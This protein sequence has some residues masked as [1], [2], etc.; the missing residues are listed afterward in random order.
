[1]QP[2]TAL[3]PVHHRRTLRAD[4]TIVEVLTVFCAVKGR[5]IR[6][7]LCNDCHRCH[8]VVLG[9]NDSPR[10]IMCDSVP[11]NAEADPGVAPSPH[12]TPVWGAMSSA[13]LCVESD[14]AAEDLAK[15]LVDASIDCAPVTDPDGVLLGVVSRLDL[16]RWQWRDGAPAVS[17]QSLMHPGRRIV[18]VMP[19]ATAGA[20]MASEGIDTLT[21]V[22]SQDRPVVVGT[23]TAR[24]VMAWLARPAGLSREGRLPG[25]DA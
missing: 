20:L 13:V 5:S 16:M 8:I 14:V 4:G 1:L 25:A 18:A 15:V 3:L 23:I 17:A 10:F 24:D 21:V 19:V 12:A 11:Q 7:G 9:R 2:S 6:T 22:A